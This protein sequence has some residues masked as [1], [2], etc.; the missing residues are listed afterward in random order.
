MNNEEVKQNGIHR[1]ATSGNIMTTPQTIF[2]LADDETNG[3]E[4]V[5]LPLTPRTDHHLLT[6]PLLN[7]NSASMSQS[8]AK[9]AD[10]ET[11]VERSRSIGQNSLPADRGGYVG[12]RISS[13]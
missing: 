1:F 10:L 4:N 7:G 5:D 3:A 2:S 13:E 8:L 6:L 11:I 12:S 9:L